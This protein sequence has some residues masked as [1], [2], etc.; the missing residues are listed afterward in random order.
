LNR[1]KAS[2]AAKLPLHGTTIAPAISDGDYDCRIY[3]QVDGECYV[4]CIA[5]L[6]FTAKKQ[7]REGCKY[8]V[9]ECYIFPG[10]IRPWPASRGGLAPRRRPGR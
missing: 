6:G 7:C 9:I 5:E 10:V 3:E 4:Q 2:L 1:Q 8:T